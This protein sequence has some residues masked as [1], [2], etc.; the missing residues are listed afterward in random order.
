MGDLFELA[1]RYDRIEYLDGCLDDVGT[2]I[3][4]VPQAARLLAGSFF[5]Q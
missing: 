5:V 4:A 1:V 3:A 2:T